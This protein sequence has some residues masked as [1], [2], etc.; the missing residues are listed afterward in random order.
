HTHPRTEGQSLWRYW[1]TGSMK[2]EAPVF[3]PER[4]SRDFV[5]F[6]PEVAR[7]GEISDKYNDL[8][9]SGG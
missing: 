4:K 3:R 5:P 6:A 7:L 9:N 2:Q 8:V 1:M